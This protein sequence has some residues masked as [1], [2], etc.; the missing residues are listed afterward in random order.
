[1]PLSRVIR[2]V[3]TAF[4]VAAA[5]GS[6]QLGAGFGLGTFSWLPTVASSGESA[7]LASLAWTVFICAT[8]V[9]IGAVIANRTLSDAGHPVWRGTIVLAAALG[10]LV[11]VLL[12]AATARAAQR[13]D[14]FAPH[15]IVASYAVAGVLVGLILSLIAVNSIAVGRNVFVTTGWLWLLAGVSAVDAY[16]AG[17]RG[18]PVQLGVWQMSSQ[19][20]WYHG[21]YLPGAILGAVAAFLIG[22]AA[23]WPAARHGA[24]RLW[25]ALSG[26]AGPL[27]AFAAYALVAPTI[28]GVN[29]ELLPAHRVVPVAVVAGLIGSLPI[30]LFATARRRAGATALPA[31]AKAED[32]KTGVVAPAEAK[33]AGDAV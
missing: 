19:G 4:L 16:A 15:V 30:A 3:A 12:A 17:R 32:D 23:A 28:R 2:T 31:P 22:A 24:N 25:T 6:A 27:L 8:S 11:V 13:A 26:A 29:H 18:G 21:V 9:V 1:M 7:W 10:G 5:A 14:T 33:V 20:P